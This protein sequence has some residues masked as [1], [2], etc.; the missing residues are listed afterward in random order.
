MGC[1][2]LTTPTTRH[3]GGMRAS[4][5]RAKTL[6]RP[7]FLDSRDAGSDRPP[8]LLL[9]PSSPPRIPPAMPI[10]KFWTRTVIVV[11]CGLTIFALLVS[12]TASMS[13]QA[14]VL[15]Q[16]NDHPCDLSIEG[17]GLGTLAANA[18]K[19]IP[20]LPGSHLFECFNSSLAK[21][22]DKGKERGILLESSVIIQISGSNQI[23]VQLPRLTAEAKNIYGAP[24]KVTAGAPLMTEQCHPATAK[25]ED[26]AG[27]V[28]I[29]DGAIRSCEG[30]GSY[31]LVRSHRSMYFVPMREVKLLVPG[32]GGG[33]EDTLFEIRGDE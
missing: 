30:V 23:V 7:A 26:L 19:S 6:G 1:D 28:S 21:A 9:R 31:L 2:L 33:A 17:T 22:R 27:V 15:V 8:A 20:L 25:G 10:R 32:N 12:G 16:N 29:V 11:R 5:R 14:P 24:G 13:G 3:D 18:S 4:N